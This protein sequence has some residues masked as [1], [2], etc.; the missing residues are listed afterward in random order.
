MDEIKICVEN[1]PEFK[2][3]IQKTLNYS[4]ILLKRIDSIKCISNYTSCYINKKIEEIEPTKLIDDLL[5]KQRQMSVLGCDQDSKNSSQISIDLD[6]INMN[7]KK[8]FYIKDVGH[9]KLTRND[10]VTIHFIDRVK[11]YMNETSLTNYLNGDTQQSFCLLYLPDYSE[12]EL[13]LAD[14][15]SKNFFQKYI[16]FLDQWLNWLISSQVING[17]KNC[18]HTST[19]EDQDENFDIITLDS[20]LKKLKR[21]NSSVEKCERVV[22]KNNSEIDSFNKITSISKL[23]NENSNFLKNLSK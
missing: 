18:E 21:F 20:Y 5:E 4:N 6:S 19:N 13:C 10:C 16:N 23:L 17:K 3:Y 14:T 2:T 9:F 1:I 15:D 22:E 8:Q 11:L 12:H 7:I